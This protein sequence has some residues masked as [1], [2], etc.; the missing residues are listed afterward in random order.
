MGKGGNIAVRQVPL[1]Q[2]TGTVFHYPGYR[3]DTLLDRHPRDHRFF[4]GRKDSYQRYGA[5]GCRCSVILESRGP[6]EGSPGCSGLS[7]RYKLG[8]PNGSA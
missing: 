1:P 5:G 2:G 7:K 8:L 3:R 6:Q 4:Q